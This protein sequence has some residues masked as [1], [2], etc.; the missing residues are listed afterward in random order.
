MS[1]LTKDTIVDLL[2]KQTD[3]P[4]TQARNLVETLLESIKEQLE[5]GAPVKIS[6]FG[7]WSVKEKKATP[8]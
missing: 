3:L 2:T 7:S 8:N 6:G 4:V 5:A 1:S